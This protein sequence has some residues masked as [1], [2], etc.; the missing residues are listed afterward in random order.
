[1]TDLCHCDNVIATASAS[2]EA[3]SLTKM[4]GL[5]TFDLWVLI[6]ALLGRWIAVS[7]S[8]KNRPW[9]F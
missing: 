1:M 5:G 2:T 8:S 9:L 4:K 6:S 3:K 7:G